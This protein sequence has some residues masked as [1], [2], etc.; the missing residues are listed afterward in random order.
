MNT[1]SRLRPDEFTI[2]MLATRFAV[3]VSALLRHERDGFSMAH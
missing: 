1:L 2:A 3:T